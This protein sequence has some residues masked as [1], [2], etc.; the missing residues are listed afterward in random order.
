MADLRINNLR[1][2][3]ASISNQVKEGRYD[4]E[5][6]SALERAYV[7]RHAPRVREQRT[8]LQ[9]GN[10]VVVLEGM[11]TARRALFLSQL[12]DNLAVVFA[13]SRDGSPVIF[14]I[15]E[16]YLLRLSVHAGLPD[17]LRIDAEGLFESRMGEGEGMGVESSE[18]VNK[19][20]KAIVSAISGVK[21]MKSY[22]CED[23]KVNNDVEFYSQEY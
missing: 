14:K 2:G 22:L 18:A 20:A 5:D 9:K 21:F 16:R 6:I 23:F 4:T 12:P 8:D 7:L 15:D 13:F 10:V 3:S 1:G 17:G 19:A 11:H